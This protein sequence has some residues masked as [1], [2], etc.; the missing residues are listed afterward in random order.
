MSLYAAVSDKFAKMLGMNTEEIIG[1]SDHDLPYGIARI[2]DVLYKQDRDV[3][4]F[5]IKMKFLDIRSYADGLEFYIFSKYPIINPSTKNVLGIYCYVT[6]PKNY[7]VINFI[8]KYQL[9][10]YPHHNQN[11]HQPLLTK[12]EQE[13]MFCIASGITERKHIANF[14]SKIHNKNIS[15]DGTIKKILTNLYQKLLI[16]GSISALYNH[17]IH[18][19]Y[20]KIIPQSI[21]NARNMRTGESIFIE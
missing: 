4:L 3:E 10:Y 17:A 5:R 15:S 20:H 12:R 16:S 18:H 21:I 19:G 9:D 2:A 1:K 13:V 7:S 8:N 14:L 6:K 11:P